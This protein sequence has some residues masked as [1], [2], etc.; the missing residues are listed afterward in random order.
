MWDLNMYPILIPQLLIARAQE[1]FDNNLRLK[2][3]RARETLKV[4]LQ[5]LVIWAAKIENQ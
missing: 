4:V 5:N 3:E 2:D 1:A